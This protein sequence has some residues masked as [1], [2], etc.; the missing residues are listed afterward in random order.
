VNVGIR[1][2]YRPNSNKLTDLYRYCG[3]N[4]DE[5][6]LP[7]IVNEVLKSVIAQYGASQLMSQRDQISSKIRSQLENRA[8]NFFIVIDDV[9]IVDLSFSPEYT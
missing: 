1:V 3:L 8:N 6:V 5:R 2:L 9:S 4:Y 7:S